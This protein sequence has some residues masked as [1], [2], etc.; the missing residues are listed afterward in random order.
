MVV[1]PAVIV[2]DGVG[3]LS[4][5]Q[6]LGGVL[7]LFGAALGSVELIYF[8]RVSRAVS[9]AS[10]D[11]DLDDVLVE[12]TTDFMLV[13]AVGG[14]IFAVVGGLALVAWAVLTRGQ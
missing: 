4:L 1:G 5:G 9:T 6:L 12:P 3:L 8:R 7:L 11:Q 2:W 13:I 10:P 14:L